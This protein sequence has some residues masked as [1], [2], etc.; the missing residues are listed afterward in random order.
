MHVHEAGPAGTT[1]ILFLHALGTSGWM[2]EPAVE[3]LA[4]RR[5]LVPDLPGHGRSAGLPWT[6]LDDT[7]DRLAD[8][9]A[10]R[11]EN[12][13]AHVVGLSMGAYV[14]LRLAAQHPARVERAVLSGLNVLPM[15]MPGL[16]RLAL[17]LM[18]PFLKTDLVL[19]AQAK[20]L[21]IPADRQAGYRAAARA[22]APDAFLRVGDE[23]MGFRLTPELARTG[24]PVL[25][26]AGERE[27]AL[28]KR[29]VAEVTGSLPRAEGRLVPGVGHGW[30]GE[31]PDLFAATLRAWLDG[32]AL[33]PELMPIRAG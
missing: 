4:E 27:H 5:C 13:R 28:I 16:M 31:A 2:W 7:V 11:A 24:Q 23:L 12:G 14:A 6:S 19:R 17:R 3:A 25:A 30:I 33:P 22:M 21:R 1:P 32:T 15:P 18:A 10:R 26:V 9:V 8:L 20:A 29:S